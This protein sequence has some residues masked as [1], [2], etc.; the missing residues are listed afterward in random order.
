MRVLPEMMIPM[1]SGVQV[2]QRTPNMRV[3]PE[4]MIPRRSGV[5]VG[6]RTPNMRVL[7]ERMIPRRSGVRKR[8]PMRVVRKRPMEVTTGN[9]SES[10]SKA[11]EVLTTYGSR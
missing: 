10:N 1:R 5:R 7:P 3:L 2:G 4:R 8:V 11:K 6:Q 9:T